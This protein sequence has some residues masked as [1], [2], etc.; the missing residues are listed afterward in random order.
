[1]IDLPSKPAAACV[2][3]AFLPATVVGS[4]VMAERLADGN[5]AALALPGNTI[6]TAAILAVVILIFGPVSGAHVD[7]VVTLAF[8]LRKEISAAKGGLY[9]AA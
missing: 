8:G 1:M 3:T 9:V 4:G 6:P 5:N 7:P 2:G